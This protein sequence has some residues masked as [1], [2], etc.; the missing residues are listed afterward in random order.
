SNE[1]LQA[2]NEELRSATEELETSKEE[3]QSVNEELSTVNQEYKEKIE[4]VGRANNDLQNLMSS[5]DIATIFLDRS[6]QIR[7][8]TPKAQYLF[9]IPPLDIGRPLE[10]FTSNL[11]Y[12]GLHE[13]GDRVLSTLQ[14]VEREVSSNKG[15]WYLARLTPYRTVE[16]KI[17]GV[18]LTFVDI[19]NRKRSE[20]QVERQSIEVK[21][22]AEMLNLAHVL[23]LDSERR[24]VLWNKGCE[25]LYGYP[26]S[27]ALGK[28]A[29]ELLK[30]EFPIPRAHIDAELQTKG[31]WEGELVHSTR[32]G[33]RKIVASHWIVHQRR[34]DQPPVI[35]EVISDITARRVAEE[36]ARE[37][38]R[39][40]D[41]FL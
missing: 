4:E 18:V 20:E 2:I 8:N 24:I 36:A 23:I 6:L 32:D 38:D 22:Q 7:R 31:Q 21:E 37:A 27:E 35:L 25:E 28:V 1:E 11:N 14:T 9:N 33:S 12:S 13:D 30:T 3:L 40:K 19:T 26:A 5:M 41:L 15:L 29:H 39:N 16:D 34:P 10:H 17:D